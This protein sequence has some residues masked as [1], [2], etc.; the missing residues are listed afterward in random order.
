[1]SQLFHTPADLTRAR[2]QADAAQALREAGAISPAEQ[3]ALLATM[4]QMHQQ[5]HTARG[6]RAARA[7]TTLNRFQT[8][9]NGSANLP[10]E[11]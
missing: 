5:D 7:A 4:W 1:M 6:E 9:L 11:E 8:R 2:D 3:E 10:G